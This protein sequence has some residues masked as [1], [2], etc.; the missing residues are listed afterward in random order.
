[1]STILFLSKTAKDGP[2]YRLVLMI[3]MRIAPLPSLVCEPFD[4]R[5]DSSSFIG[6]K[7]PELMHKSIL[8]TPALIREYPSSKEGGGT[9][10]KKMIP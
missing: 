10:P 8:G 2:H 5:W 3:D 6:K 9:R 7:I 4:R 1:L